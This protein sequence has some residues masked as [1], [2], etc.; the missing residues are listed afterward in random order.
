MIK[1]KKPRYSKDKVIVNLMKQTRC[2]KSK[3]IVNLKKHTWLGQCRHAFPTSITKRHWEGMILREYRF[4]NE[5]VLIHHRF[6][7]GKHNI[8]KQMQKTQNAC[9]IVSKRDKCVKWIT[10]QC[11]TMAKNEKISRCNNRRLSKIMK[12][13]QRYPLD[14]IS[15]LILL[16]L[17]RY[18]TLEVWTYA[19]KALYII[20]MVNW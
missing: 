9:L 7:S 17:E 13:P 12:Q 14:A 4:S 1:K 8:H 19:V 5:K 3:L 20:Q 11:F 18:L 2:S 10:W 6:L 15:S 16:F